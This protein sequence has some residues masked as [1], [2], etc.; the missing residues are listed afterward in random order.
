MRPAFL[1]VGL[2]LLG[3]AA[4]ASAQAHHY[5]VEVVASYPHDPKAFTEGLLWADGYLYESIG[6]HGES[7]LRKVVLQTGEVKDQYR[8][9]NDYF[10]EGLARVGDR[11]IQLSWKEHRGFV[12]DLQTLQPVAHFSYPGEGWG[13]AW[14]GERLVMSDGTATL[15]FLEGQS[16]EE[17]DRIQVHYRG[18]PISRLNEL[19]VIKGQIWANVW[20]TDLIVRIDPDNGQV[21][22]II[23]AGSLREQLPAGFKV[24]VL[25]GI[26]Y[27]PEANRIFLT[28]KYWPRLF[29][30]RLEPR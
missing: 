9:A 24:D 4:A 20:R 13:L 26:A 2:G 21:V 1:F 30:V 3:V 22:G 7:A 12:Y 6:L 27:D 15:R 14:D 17:M 11:L 18:K 25:N 8:V 5:T 23:H 16:Y 29:Q 10:A 28:G 19:A